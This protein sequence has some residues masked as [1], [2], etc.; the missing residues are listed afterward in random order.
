MSLVDD[1]WALN[2]DALAFMCGCNCV[3][4]FQTIPAPLQPDIWKQLVS[5]T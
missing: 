1:A 4:W 5:G 2:G 3:V